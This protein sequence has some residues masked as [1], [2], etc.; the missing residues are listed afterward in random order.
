MINKIKII[1]K[2]Y[3]LFFEKN[4]FKLK[5]PSIITFIYLIFFNN[6]DHG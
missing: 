5:M 6:G 4:Y 3:S 1:I 2:I